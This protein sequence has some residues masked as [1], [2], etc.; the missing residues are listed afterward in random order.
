MRMREMN[1]LNEKKNKNKTETKLSE[2]NRSEMGD[3]MAQKE[4]EL[5][6]GNWKAVAV[7]RINH[8]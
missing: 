1:H 4:E 3:L 7:C 2:T 5:L 6:F 8:E